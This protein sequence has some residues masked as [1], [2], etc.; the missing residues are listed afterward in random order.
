MY[1]DAEIGILRCCGVHRV[2]TGEVKLVNTPI[3]LEDGEMVNTGFTVAD[4]K[5]VE[6]SPINPGTL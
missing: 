3:I 4:R 1:A 6:F 5:L 2:F